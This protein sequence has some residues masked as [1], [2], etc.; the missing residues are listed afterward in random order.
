[1]TNYEQ[2]NTHEAELR[3]QENLIKLQEA[4]TRKP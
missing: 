1:M 2:P 3:N 4:L